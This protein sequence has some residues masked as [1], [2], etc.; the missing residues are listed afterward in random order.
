M[1]GFYQEAGIAA[2]L[3]ESP[4]AFEETIA[5]YHAPVLAAV[6]Q[7]NAYLRSSTAGCARVRG[8]RFTWI[9]L[10]APN[11]VHTR[12]YKSDYFIVITPSAELRVDD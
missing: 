1:I 5:R 3:E 7:V 10:G 6:N 8:F 9:W 2:A 4:A 11:Q 12:T